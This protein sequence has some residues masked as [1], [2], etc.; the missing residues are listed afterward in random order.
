MARTQETC[1]RCGPAR[2]LG[3]RFLIS[4]HRSGRIVARTQE[5]CDRCGP[6]RQLGTRFLISGHRSGRI[7]ARTQETCDPARPRAARLEGAQARQDLVAVEL[8]ETRLVGAG[9]VEDQVRE[10]QVQV[11]L[12]LLDVLVGV[13]GDDEPLGGLLDGQL[14]GQTVASRPGPRRPASA[15]R[16]ARARPRNGWRSTALRQ[17]SWSKETLTS[18]IMSMS[19]TERFGFFS[20]LRLDRQ[21]SACRCRGLGVLARRGDVA[22]ALPAGEPGRRGARGR[23]PDR[24]LAARAGRRSWP[25][26]SCSSHPRR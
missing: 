18:I 10:A 2:Q 21:A 20:A 8:Q 19:S 24:H 7:V 5:T 23:E 6:A 12:D 15:P 22:V 1:D 11:G 13:G 16:S 14:V 9:G 25:C 3:T 26:P 4:G 17:R